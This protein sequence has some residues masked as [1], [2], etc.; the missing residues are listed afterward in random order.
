MAALC[1]G[2]F[3]ILVDMT[4]VAVANPA[5]MA[6]LST[7]IDHVVWV[8]S[9]YLLCYAAP[10]LLTGRLGDSFGPKNVYL[11]GLAVFTAASLACGLSR[12]VEQLIAARAAQ[13]IGA[14]L[15]TPQTMAVI[16]RLFPP[17]R[18]VAAMSAWS[19]VAGV[20]T[21]TGPVVGGLLV[22]G[23]GWEWIFLVNVPVGII[24]FVAAVYG[25]PRFDTSPHRF[26]VVGIL[27]SS[28]GLLLLVFGVQEGN[29]Y[30]WS[31]GIC[32]AIVG[33]SV[34]LIVFVVHQARVRDDSLLPIVVIRNRNFVVGN[35]ATGLVNGALAALLVL[36]FFYAQIVRGLTPVQS[37]LVFSPMAVVTGVLAPI[38]GRLSG[39]FDARLVPA[40]GFVTFAAGIVWLGMVMAPE[41]P[42]MVLIPPIALMGVANACIWAPLGAVVTHDVPPGQAGA[43]AGVFNTTRQTCAALGTAGVGAVINARLSAHAIP[44]AV[45]ECSR[46]CRTPSGHP[47]EPRSPSR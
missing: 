42:V 36:A 20:A 45:A 13:G 30:H 21:L 12:N 34:L 38:V 33:G 25:V 46:P 43:A 4:I 41:A 11:V 37:A 16:T 39:R 14:A 9:A 10:L 29:A 17:D 32:S 15:I 8:T 28:L 7:D 18:R 44:T 19:A 35:V 22:D 3:M 26:D 27:V 6:G 5:I 47:S 1:I 31:A 23:Y 40:I 2:F 24:G